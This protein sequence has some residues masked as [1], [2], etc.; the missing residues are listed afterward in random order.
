MRD[1]FEFPTFFLLPYKT[2]QKCAYALVEVAVKMFV[3]VC[4]VLFLNLN[5]IMDT[6]IHSIF[7]CVHHLY[8]RPLVT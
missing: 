2:K 3:A 7:V 1:S 6:G 5:V 8:M 4:Q